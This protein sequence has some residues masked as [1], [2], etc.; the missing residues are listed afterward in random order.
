MAPSIYSA[1]GGSTDV[2]RGRHFYGGAII[3]PGSVKK[4]ES[5]DFPSRSIRNFGKRFTGDG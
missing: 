5:I 2:T 3:H 1:I 4:G